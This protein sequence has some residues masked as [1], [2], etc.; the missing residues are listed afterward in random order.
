LVASSTK[1]DGRAINFA[2]DLAIA[3]TGEIYFSDALD[4]AHFF[5][6]SFWQTFFHHKAEGR[7]LVYDPKTKVTKTVLEKLY[8]TNG[9]ELSPE[10][11]VL[12]VSQT[13][14]RSI[15]K[16]HLKGPK[17][18]QL[19]HFVANLPGFTDN[20]RL[21]ERGTYWIAF[22][23]AIDPQDPSLW[24]RITCHITR[25]YVYSSLELLNK[26]LQTVYSLAPVDF[27]KTLHHSVLELL[28]ESVYQGDY[29]L[30]VEVNAKGEILRSL[31]SP[32]GVVSR[33]SQVTEHQGTLYIASYWNG[34]IGKVKLPK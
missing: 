3:K 1:V 31:H 6:K 16:Y 21:N 18:G 27:V 25:Y 26:L 9:V 15:L 7:V 10:E 8:F 19:E 12:F 28:H 11:D 22:C 20:I 4:D 5:Q 14:D 32:K 33:I 17:K 13:L 30:I 24:E 2:D 23:A 34:F 29:G